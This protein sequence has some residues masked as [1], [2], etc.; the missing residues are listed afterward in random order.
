[1]TKNKEAIMSIHMN[2]TK[3]IEEA[4]E[5]EEQAL[6]NVE[7]AQEEH[8]QKQCETLAWSA[9]MGVLEEAPDLF[10]GDF[11]LLKKDFISHL[12]SLRKECPQACD[13]AWTYYNHLVF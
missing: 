13:I 1:M 11:P 8:W 4:K 9:V 12:G 7:R 2:I 3:W 5:R 6:E 10:D